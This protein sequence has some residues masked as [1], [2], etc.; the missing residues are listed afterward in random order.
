MYLSNDGHQ[1][2]GV[3]LQ[4]VQPGRHAF[5]VSFRKWRCLRYILD[6]SLCL[7]GTLQDPLL[8]LLGS[9]TVR[10]KLF[11]LNKTG[12]VQL[13]GASNPLAGYLRDYAPLCKRHSHSTR[14]V[15]PSVE[16]LTAHLVDQ[17]LRITCTDAT[18]SFDRALHAPDH[19]GSLDVPQSSHTTPYIIRIFCVLV[20]YS[21][22]VLFWPVETSSH[23]DR[24][25]R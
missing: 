7:G 13:S 8:T 2:A 11:W 22:A 15:A 14:V 4:T 16:R 6:R 10:C 17:M 1:A 9:R 5:S 21:T 19:F 18:I 12:A 23:L 24:Q 3:P 20:V 25:E